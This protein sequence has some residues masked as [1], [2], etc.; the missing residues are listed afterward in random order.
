MVAAAAGPLVHARWRG[1]TAFPRAY[2]RRRAVAVTTNEVENSALNDLALG[3]VASELAWDA[4]LSC[5]Q[6]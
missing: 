1:Y 4:V 3:V 5:V 6:E 2:G